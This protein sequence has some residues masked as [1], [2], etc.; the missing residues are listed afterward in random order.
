M[1]AFVCVANGSWTAAASGKGDISDGFQD[2]RLLDVDFNEGKATHFEK[3]VSFAGPLGFV[4]GA[5][6]KDF[7]GTDW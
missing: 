1:Q 5:L 4:F 6:A 2:T 7:P 3:S